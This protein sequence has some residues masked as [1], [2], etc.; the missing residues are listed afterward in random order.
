MNTVKTITP[1]SKRE[2]D[3]YNLLVDGLTFDEIAEKCFVAP[4]T[5]K[6]HAQNIY[7]KCQVPSRLKLIVQ[8]YKAAA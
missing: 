7:H 5:V 2:I 3:I 8:H 6:F 1:L 4:R